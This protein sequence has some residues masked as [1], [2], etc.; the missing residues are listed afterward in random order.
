MDKP[1]SLTAQV[2]R[3]RYF[4]HGYFMEASVGVR[5]STTWRSIIQA[6]GFFERRIRM[7]IGNG[8][9]TPV[10]NNAW[11]P[12][13]GNFCLI[14]PPPSPF[15]PH[16]VADLIDP[17][18]R[19]WNVELIQSSFWEVDRG[20]ILAIPIG[21]IET[22]DKVVWHYSKDGRFTVRSCYHLISQLL[23]GTS[24]GMMS[25][26][27]YIRWKE[28]WKLPIPPKIRMFVWR[29]CTG[30]L[31]HK[32]ELFRHHLVHSPICDRS[33]VEEETII[34]AIMRCRG[35]PEI[36]SEEPFFLPQM[37]NRDSMWILIQALKKSLSSDLFLISLVVCWKLWEGRNLDVHGEERSFPADVV[38]WSKAFLE[39]YRAAQGPQQELF[40]PVRPETWSPPKEDFI[41][42][43][44]DVALPEGVDFYRISFIARN[45]TGECLWWQRRI[46]SGRPSPADSEAMAVFEGVQAALVR[47]WPR[48]IVET[49]CYQ[50][51]Q[52]LASP[53][54]VSRTSF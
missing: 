8:F 39:A 44:V 20:R 41:K 32:A 54:L 47:R 37:E 11:I 45:S 15:F 16:Q 6:R 17:I 21:S 31:P 43:N 5:Q 51:Y 12:K 38:S 27:E 30:I 40:S 14:T 22:E 7:R 29:A 9:A 35:L 2:F 36:W 4:P 19:Q 49:D 18:T 1:E 33:G 34:H 13:D 23:N 25:G 28:V 24:G 46:C 48:V 50:V 53:R 26:A 3:A 52:Y 10:W 42:I